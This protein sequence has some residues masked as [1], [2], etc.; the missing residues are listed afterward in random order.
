MKRVRENIIRV[1]SVSQI[2]SIT[3]AIFSF[4][5]LLSGAEMVG[6][7]KSPLILMM[8]AGSNAN[9]GSFLLKEAFSFS[10]GTFSANVPVTYT[11]SNG[12]YS[13]VQGSTTLNVPQ[14]EMA[15]LVNSG[16]IK[17]E[18]A[19]KEVTFLE[20]SLGS[21]PFGIT[22]TMGHLVS[23]IIWGGI[24]WGVGRIVGSMLG[25]DHE[26]TNT[27]S[28]ALSVGVSI[29]RFGFLQATEGGFA[30]TFFNSL[31]FGG[32][33]IPWTLGIS[34]VVF[35]LMYRNE[36]LKRVT[37]S[38]LPWEAPVGGKSC[39]KCNDDPF[40]PCSE[41]RC[42][43]LGQAC[44][45]VNSGT[46]DEKC[47]WVNPNDVTSPTITP[48]DAPLT[49]GHK[50][51]NHDTR[52]LS[53]GVKIT[54]TTVQNKCLKAFTPL[55]FGI[56]TNEPAQCKIDMVH[57]NSSDAMQFFMGNGN[58]FAYNHTQTF[59]LPSPNAINA[60]APELQNDGK[61][62][63][64]IR[65]RDKN[66]NENVDEYAVQFCVD[67]SPDET[68]PTIVETSIISGSYVRFGV[69]S[70]PLQVYVNEPA[71]CKW[72]HQ[73]KNYETMENSMNCAT[74]L[75]QINARE[76]YTCSAN[77]TG[78]V[79][80][81]ENKF[82]FR[83]KDQP[84]KPEKDR[85]AMVISY[86]FILKGSQPLNIIEVGP[87]A[88]ITGN[89]QT[90]AV[91]LTLKTD[92][93]AEEGKSICSISNTGVAGS[94]TALFETNAVEHKQTLHLGNGAYNYYFRCVDSGG[95]AV[96]ANASFNVYIDTSPPMITRAYH[97]SSGSVGDALKIV[98]NEYASC[99]YS[100][101][102]CNYN[103]NEGVALLH[104]S[105]LLKKNH[106]TEWRPNIVY[107]LKCRDDFG[108]E[109]APNACSLVA[110]ASAIA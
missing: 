102:S 105:Q 27:L 73:D 86:P 95:N 11:T 77:L 28:T 89:T 30:Q 39:E 33:S 19:T 82:Y 53:R 74:S 54:R 17:L 5:F 57:K 55:V 41:Y 75:T 23:G 60:E 50:Y 58:L 40:R 42:K 84:S 65:C 88:T 6:A 3:C 69:Q 34:A 52:P 101:N 51:N 61:Y 71:E 15:R 44:E 49:E 1:L 96:E 66:G 99:V 37:F 76:L 47:I 108:N 20:N 93:G 2:V 83:C 9:S 68:P 94:F 90:V 97:D 18:S 46:K 70:V 16:A 109:P 21:Q 31:G 110:S 63:F 43:S 22:G 26:T 36:S 104:V 56:T 100:L 32:Y 106:Y 14:S 13:L 25:L 67:P 35:I 87:N 7:Q 10:G 12:A 80:R 45:I 98:T 38:C 59:R 62:E 64:F 79:D 29:T 85:I 4:V 48:W 8:N 24:A 72:S 78:I 81:T 91:N 107:Y 92:D 103:F